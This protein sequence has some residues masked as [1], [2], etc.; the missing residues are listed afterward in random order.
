MARSSFLVLKPTLAWVLLIVASASAFALAHATVA[1]S[2]LAS[3]VTRIWPFVTQSPRS[4]FTA[5][6]IPST[7]GPT[8]TSRYGFIT[9][10]MS[11]A[12]AFVAEAAAHQEQTL[13]TAMLTWRKECIRQLLLVL[14]KAHAALQSCRQLQV[15]VRQ[16]ETNTERTARR[17]HNSI[18]D[19]YLGRIFSRHGRFRFHIG[20]GAE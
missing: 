14:S 15:M 17:V 12:N 16:F 19:G 4:T 1:S 9:Q 10:A 2:T 18:D 8:D 7:G 13:T 6:M 5:W 20:R 3:S 11:P